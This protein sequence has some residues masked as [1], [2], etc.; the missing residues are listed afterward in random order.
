M[1]LNPVAYTEN[2]V[3][4][5]LRYQLTAFPFADARLHAQWCIAP[6]ARASWCSATTAKMPPFKQAGCATTPAASACG[7]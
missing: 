6:N 3:K 1:V 7:R 4:S 2:V 5:F